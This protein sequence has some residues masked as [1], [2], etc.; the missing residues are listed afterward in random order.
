MRPIEITLP[1]KPS[2]PSRRTTATREPEETVDSGRSTWS[3]ISKGWALQGSVSI[4]VLPAPANG[5]YPIL[6]PQCGKIE[7]LRDGVV[8][9][10]EVRRTAPDSHHRHQT[11]PQKTVPQDRLPSV[12]GAAGVVVAAR[13]E[14]GRDDHLIEPDRK[15]YHQTK[16][17]S[18]W[19]APF[20]THMMDEETRR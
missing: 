13:W 20:R 5:S 17:G 4:A 14:K 19:T 10:V 6:L 16:D 15:R 1:R 7:A 12:L 18:H 8:P 11:A 2:P 9:S 3:F